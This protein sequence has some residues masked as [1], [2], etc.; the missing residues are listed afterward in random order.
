MGTKKISAL[1]PKAAN[2]EPT[3][4]FA[5]VK[6]DGT[7]V[8][9]FRTV[10][11]TGQ[12]LLNVLSGA[13][14]LVNDL[15]PQLGGDLDV[16]GFS[17]ITIDDQDIILNPQGLGIVK[18][19]KDV[20]IRNTSG[21]TTA[22]RLLLYE[23][24]TNG[25]NYIGIK[26]PDSLGVNTV[27]TLPATDGTVGQI[28]STNGSGV[29]SWVTDTGGTVDFIPKVS[30]FNVQRFF[31]FTNNST[32]V[33]YSGL[34]VGALSGT[35]SALAL[36]GA[37]ATK[38][39]RTRITSSTL[40]GSIAGYR[41][42]GTDIAIGMGFHAVFTF[43]F[44]DSVF[45]SSAHNWVG[46]GASATFQIGSLTYASSLG[47]I[48]GVGNDPTDTTL[49]IMHNN[50]TGSA[51][52][53]PLGTDFP[54]NRTAGTAF[55]GMFCFELFN[56][57]GSQDVKWRITRID[58]GTVEQGTITSTDKPSSTTFLA[59]VISRSNGSSSSVAAIMDIACIQIF[60]KH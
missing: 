49:Q 16:T 35:Q 57:Y 10:Y 25:N 4:R 48:I 14:E 27:Y 26:A 43:G 3:D 17:I 38:V 60:T 40:S 55:T 2:L 54:A 56:D 33:F 34:L 47:N 7:S 46:F 5:A 59:P 50:S 31:V 23:A 8:T 20:H 15:S 52:K 36:A 51:I 1:P 45:N 21:A 58:T 18:M 19:E 6:V 41:G 44:A 13:F 42:N 32:T 11:I 12:E 53:I 9:G 24:Q 29:L 28:L 30:G 39:I 37:T 22:L